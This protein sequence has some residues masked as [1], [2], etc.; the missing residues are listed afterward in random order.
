MERP[1]KYD[2]VTNIGGRGN[3]GRTRKKAFAE[4]T[5]YFKG[6]IRNNPSLAPAAGLSSEGLLVIVKVLEDSDMMNRWDYISKKKP[7][8][9]GEGY[10]NAQPNSTK[11]GKLEKEIGDRVRAITV[12]SPPTTKTVGGLPPRQPRIDHASDTQADDVAF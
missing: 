8:N 10:Y 1:G 9:T 5:E 11:D 7:K 4:L 6:R 3:G 2:E 12:K